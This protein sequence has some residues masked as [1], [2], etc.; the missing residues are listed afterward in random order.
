M[1]QKL[2]KTEILRSKKIIGE[3]FQKSSSSLYT[4][5]FQIRYLPIAETSSH[6]P[7]VLFV[8][9]KKN[10]RKAH[11]RNLVRRRIKEAYRLC[12]NTYLTQLSRQSAIVIIY[13]SKEILD[14]ATIQ[15]KL[16][17]VFQLFPN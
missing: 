10:I 17:K 12:K 7:Q 13:V 9:S 11:Q 5:P 2:P 14:F 1:N 15:K 16:H 4:Y 6:L 8:I 3:L